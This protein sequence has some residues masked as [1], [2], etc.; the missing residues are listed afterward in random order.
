MIPRPLNIDFVK[1]C[2]ILKSLRDKPREQGDLYLLACRR[3]FNDPTF[4]FLKGE[5]NELKSVFWTTLYTVDVNTVSANMRV[6]TKPF[7]Q[8]V[9]LAELEKRVIEYFKKGSGDGSV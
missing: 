9:D 1:F 7:S 4:E 2:S 6:S 3:Y 8:K 5:R